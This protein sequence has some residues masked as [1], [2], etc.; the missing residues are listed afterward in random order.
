MYSPALF[1]FFLGKLTASLPVSA[2]HCLL[3]GGKHTRK[4]SKTELS[5]QFSCFG[6]LSSVLYFRK[7][8]LGFE[9][10]FLSISSL[11][12]FELPFERFACEPLLL[13]C[14]K[15]SLI[16]NFKNKKNPQTKQKKL[17]GLA[18][19]LPCF[20]SSLGVSTEQLQGVL[21]KVMLVRRSSSRQ[22]TDNLSIYSFFCTQTNVLTLSSL[23]QRE[24]EFICEVPSSS[25]T[26]VET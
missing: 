16:S 3:V 20:G 21:F 13:N 15:L 14:N 23:Q 2:V 12:T 10:T 24:K 17:L 8:G 25:L 7:V 26:S 1:S 6:N 18:E 19:P 5:Y 11:K 4:T 9:Q 22:M